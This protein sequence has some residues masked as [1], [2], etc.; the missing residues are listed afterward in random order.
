M[1][2]SSL[3]LVPFAFIACGGDDSNITLPDGSAA[4]GTVTDSPTSDAPAADSSS[5]DGAADSG[6]PDAAGCSDNDAGR[7]ACLKCCGQAHPT[8][9]QV[10][11]AALEACAC[12]PAICGANDAGVDG[13]GRFGKSECAKTCGTS[14]PPDNACATCLYDSFATK[15]GPGPCA[16]SEQTACKSDQACKA[17]EACAAKCP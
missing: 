1:N 3:L 2:R 4:D 10:F 6:T 12:A 11:R 15:N 7:G 8:G 5:D 9:E 14:T 16:A 17:F 13:G